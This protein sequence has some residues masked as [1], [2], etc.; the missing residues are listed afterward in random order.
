ML[1][2]VPAGQGI[3][4]VIWLAVV[5]LLILAASRAVRLL[6]MLR[7]TA[8]PAGE[9]MLRGSLALDQ[10]RRLHLVEV[11]GR[12]ALVLTGGGSDV[13]LTLPAPGC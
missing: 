5:V 4:A 10:R 2:G 11:G 1:I 12:Q 3:M 9:L 6:P 7:Q 8:Q 13:L